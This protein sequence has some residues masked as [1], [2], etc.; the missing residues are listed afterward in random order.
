[1]SCQPSSRSIVMTLRPHWN[2]PVGVGASVPA[3]EG[4]QVA[5]GGESPTARQQEAL[6]AESAAYSA[7]SQEISE[8]LE[9]LEALV[10]HIKFRTS[11]R[12]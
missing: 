4:S 9:R 3:G 8:R 2:E 7:A 12:R 6:A 5:G 10:R 1:M 11:A